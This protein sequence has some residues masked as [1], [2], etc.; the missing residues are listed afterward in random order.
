MSTAP[1]ARPL[2]RALH[3]EG[4]RH[5]V[6]LFHGLSSSPLE[7]Q[8]VARGLHR[9]G[10]SVHVP[11]MAGY[12]Y[13]LPGPGG[14][15]ARHW[16]KVALEQFDQLSRDYETVSVG[17]LCLGAVLALQVAALRARQVAT[18]LSLSTALHYDG[19]GN[20]WYTALLPMAR[21]IPF[22][23]RIRIQE[24]SPFGL[25]DERMRG[26]IERQMLEASQS[27]AGAASLRVADLLQARR[28][29]T[30]TRRRLPDIIAPTLLLHALEDE[31]AT[32]RSAYEV[33]VRVHA[34]DV[35][36]VMLHDSY[37]M[38]S[39]DREKELV[40]NEMVQF[41]DHRLREN[42]GELSSAAANM[43]TL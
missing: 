9:A 42:P 8:F 36:L 16:T 33:A 32:P 6:L 29:I 1:P 21:W 5:A 12:T 23:P 2:P 35:H 28:L 31:C 30:A 20:P 38:I 11:V 22:A 43:S 14:S 34:T 40:L 17:G 7:L 3:F 19:W 41:L 26:W 15:S 10:Y 25:K 13:G 27:D 24:K 37:H 4:G 18:V 39:L